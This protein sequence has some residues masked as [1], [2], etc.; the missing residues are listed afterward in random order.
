VCQ[1]INRLAPVFRLLYGFGC[2]VAV[3]QAGLTVVSTAYIRQFQVGLIK[4]HPGLVRNIERR[5]ENQL[6]VQSLLE[7][8]KHTSTQ[9][10]ATGV[11]FKQEWQ[12]LVELGVTGGQ[13]D[14]F[15]TSQPV[16]SNVKKYSQRYRV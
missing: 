16:N 11:R 13:G 4:L 7:S 8:C 14:F 5:T 2:R 3:T 6:F 10:F 12:T 15:A 9:V 1:H